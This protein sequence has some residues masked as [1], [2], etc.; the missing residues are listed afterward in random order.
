MPR[1]ARRHLAI[2]Q[3]AWL[4]SL[5]MCASLAAPATPDDSP[6]D[7]LG[8]MAYALEYLNYQGTLVQLE[9]QEPAV[10]RIVHRVED[11]VPTERITA[12]DGVGRE[13]IRH[14]DVVTCI[15]PDQ[16]L[17][18]VEDRDGEGRKASP[19]Q[20]QFGG[21]LSVDDRYYRLA[22][23][24]GGKLL[25]RATNVITMRP[26]DNFRYGYRLWLDHATA[27]PLK[28]QVTADDGSVVEQLL[29]SDISLP[30]SIPASAVQATRA[31]DDYTWHRS[32]TMPGTQPAGSSAA[33]WTVD[34]PPP[35]FTLRTVR[36]QRR[37][38]V[39]AGGKATATDEATAG[40]AEAVEPIRQLVF[41]D[42]VASVSV[43]VEAGVKAVERSEGSSRIGAA[44]AYTTMAADHL[45][46]AMGEVPARTVEAMARSVRP[47]PG[48]E[49]AARTGAP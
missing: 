43:F 39:T 24:T 20:R 35:G 8:R 21:K 5:A 48:A 18:L 28:I 23:A 26:A 40:D 49:S 30:S 38:P 46:T 6:R 4:L 29:F 16:H 19:L 27:M 17:V 42:G 37:S 45:I 44:N 12:L 22:I 13:I 41:S 2:G 15:L 3:V 14:G 11:G 34:D 47:P 10:M 32:A 25:G 31:T 33:G 1:L 36:A 9:G 7:W